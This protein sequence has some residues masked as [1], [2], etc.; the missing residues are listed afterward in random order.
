MKMSPVKRFAQKK[1]ENFV[2]RKVNVKMNKIFR[3]FNVKTTVLNLSSR[4]FINYVSGGL[5]EPSYLEAMKSKI[6]L[7]DLI[8]IQLKGYDYPVLENY[9][10]FLH[11][12]LKNMEVNVEECWAAP[13]QHMQISAYKP[14]SEIVN[15]QYNLMIYERTLQITDISSFQLPLIIRTIETSLPAGVTVQV[16]PHEEYDEEVRYIPDKELD[17]LK[18]EL[19]ELGGPSKTKK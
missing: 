15:A 10:K 14:K 19:E 13:A 5:Y 12:L 17:T 9:Q 7:H 8:N 18:Q 16:K 6:P 11:H 1:K 2:T 3:K 4:R